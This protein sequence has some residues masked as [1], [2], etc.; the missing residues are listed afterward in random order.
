MSVRITPSIRQ[1]RLQEFQELIERLHAH[2]L[3]AIIDLM[4]NHV[5]RSYASCVK[6]DCDFGPCGCAGAG[7]DT[8]KFFD[9]QNNFF[10]LTPD[11]N[12]PSAPPA[13]RARGRA[14]QRDVPGCSGGL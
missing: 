5:A 7:D 8:T 11:G 10:Y 1:K 14:S 6:P 4:A 12:G 13:D 9:P 3:K 2:G